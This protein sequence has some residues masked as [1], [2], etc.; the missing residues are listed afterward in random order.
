[1]NISGN[2]IGPNGEEFEPPALPRRPFARGARASRAARCALSTSER[3]RPM[4]KKA[5]CLRPLRVR[6]HTGRAG[7][8]V[9]RPLWV[10]GMGRARRNSYCLL[11]WVE[12]PSRHSA[13]VTSRVICVALRWNRVLSRC[14]HRNRCTSCA[15]I[16]QPSFNPDHVSVTHHLK[17]SHIDETADAVADAKFADGHGRGIV[18]KNAPAPSVRQLLLAPASPLVRSAQRPLRAGMKGFACSSKRPSWARSSCPCPRRRKVKQLFAWISRAFAGD[19]QYNNL[20]LRLRAVWARAGN[21]LC[22][23]CGQCDA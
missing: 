12:F 5:R 15:S 21:A 17:L 4:Q 7:S 22:A 13:Q 6:T 11:G 10:V 16:D 3:A 18:C 9:A 14:V 20:M 19:M 23:A 2:K 8:V 1:M